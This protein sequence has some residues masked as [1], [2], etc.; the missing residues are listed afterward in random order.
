[1]AA[2]LALAGMSLSDF[3]SAKRAIE[4]RAPIDLNF[5]PDRLDRKGR[6]VSASLLASG[7]YKNQFEIGLSSGGLT[8][9]EGGKRDRWEDR[10]FGGAYQEP[11]VAAQ[12]RP[13]YG[14]LNLLGHWDGACPRF[15]CCYFRLKPSLGERC[16]FT[17]GDSVAEPETIATI[18][19]F[20]AVL[21]DLLEDIAT[22]GRA[23]GGHDLKLRALLQ[24]LVAVA[25][26]NSPVE[27]G[28]QPG[29]CLD[30]VIEAQVHGP[31]RLAS[32]VDCLVADRVFRDANS[33]RD[34]IELSARY[35]FPLL[36]HPGFTLPI[37]AVP[38]DFRGPAM[39]P[40]ARHIAPDGLLDAAKIGQA[41]A[42]LRRDP[43]GWSDWGSFDETLQYLKQLWHV[44]AAFG[45]AGS[46]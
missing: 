13:K 31:V 12:D 24:D 6:R 32:D 21:A 20:D 33:G 41:A 16:T 38:A 4:R 27:F 28:G 26:R 30:D 34:L 25:D 37:S 46:D 1:M 45:A 36:W 42:S 19:T 29:R 35:K 15:G 22:T 17:Y 3:D 40:L 9:F 5:H 7:L 10:L 2:H 14:A 8:A 23:L 39:V 43:D 18:G 44:L 11:G